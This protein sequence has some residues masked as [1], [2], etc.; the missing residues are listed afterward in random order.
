VNQIQLSHLLLA[1]IQSFKTHRILLG[2]LSWLKFL[3]SY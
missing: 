3:V 1:F 2:V